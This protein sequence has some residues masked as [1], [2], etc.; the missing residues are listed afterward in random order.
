MKQLTVTDAEIAETFHGEDLMFGVRIDSLLEDIDSLVIL[1][2]RK[3]E[4][5][6]HGGFRWKLEIEYEPD[7]EE[8]LVSSDG[9]EIGRVV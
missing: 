6:M 5:G 8:V 1:L 2:L 9:R 4:Q 3:K 7:E